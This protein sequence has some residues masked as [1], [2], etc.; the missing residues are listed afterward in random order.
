MVQEVDAAPSGLVA[1]MQTQITSLLTANKILES[2]LAAEKQSKV[3]SLADK[4]SLHQVI[5]FSAMLHK[6]QR[7]FS[8]LA[9]L[10][11]SSRA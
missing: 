10:A 4:E 11:V 8:P 6:R 3:T 1:Q 2:K 5:N 7:D 9:N